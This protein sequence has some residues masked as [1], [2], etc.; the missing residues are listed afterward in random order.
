MKRKYVT[1]EEYRDK[2]EKLKQGGHELAEKLRAALGDD[3]DV[4]A[5]LQSLQGV[6]DLGEQYLM[7]AVKQNELGCAIIDAVADHCHVTRKQ[8]MSRDRAQT[9]VNARQIAM[10]I[11]REQTGESFS[12][13]ARAFGTTPATVSHHVK[14]IMRRLDTE[15]RLRKEIK[16]IQKAADEAF[17]N[18]T[19]L[20]E[21]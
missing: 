13:I 19:K 21:C 7:D 18:A 2:L 5:A 11:V 10:Y 15:R 9:T 8:I 14:T 1:V 4:A 17:E 16:E 20:E 3:K 12:S 6:I